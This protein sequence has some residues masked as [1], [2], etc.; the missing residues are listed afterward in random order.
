MNKFNE[1]IVEIDDILVYTIII[2][3]KSNKDYKY[4]LIIIEKLSQYVT[5]QSHSGTK[6]I[7]SFSYEI[8]NKTLVW[9]IG[10]LIQGEEVIISY[11][12]KISSGNF[13]DII[14]NIGFVGII[15]SSTVKN[16]I[17]INLDNKKRINQK[18]F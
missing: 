17:G 9:N 14:E 6:K 8:D 3:N 11:L 1:A 2:K 10:K 18:K 12:V 16:K 5:Y 7:A 13:G 4:D 15:P